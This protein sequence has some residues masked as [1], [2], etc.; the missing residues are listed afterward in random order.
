MK[1]WLKHAIHQSAW[2]PLLV[3]LFYAIAAKGFNAYLIY[4]WLDMPTHFLGGAAIT[5]FFLCA[6]NHGQAL[7]G[8]IPVLIRKLLALGLTA[9]TAIV[10]EF[11]EF[12]SDVA[13]GT[14]MNL[15]VADTLADLFFG[16]LGGVVVIA[17]QRAGAARP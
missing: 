1:P 11:L 15:G 5:Y 8:E 2:A 13:L 9:T 17:L 12:L 14:K 6:I 16:L 7:L 10:W 4:P 3:L